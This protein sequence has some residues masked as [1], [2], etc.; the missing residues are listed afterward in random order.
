MKI[1]KIVQQ[2]KQRD[3]YSIFVDDRY[4]FSLGEG[5]L[6]S[7]GLTSGQE[8]TGQQI[9]Q[10]EQ[11][12]AED[13]LYNRT[14]RYVAM[15]PRSVWEV[16][17]YLRRKEAPAPLVA[18]IITKLSGLDLLN[19]Q[20]FAEQFVRDR[21][22]LRSASTRKLTLELQKKR[23]S[24]DIIERVL[25]A[26]ETDELA[27]LK[28]LIAKKQRQSKYKEDSLKLMQYLARQG[29]SYGDIKTAL[30]ADD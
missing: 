15:R 10:Y 3:R 21:R 20:R 8:L 11:L 28:A 26:D 14:L 6:L 12:S 22:L 18:Q 4:A 24:S 13:K 5:A 29:F 17:F 19:D 30:R 1:T 25:A 23:I 9:N 27:M 16:E 7:T 2:Q